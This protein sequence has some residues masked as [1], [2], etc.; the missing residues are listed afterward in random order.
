MNLDA[1]K[2]ITNGFMADD[3]LKWLASA[4]MKHRRIVEI[5][6]WTG[7]STRALTDNTPGVVYAVDTWEGCPNGDLKDILAEK[8][9]EW[10]F[11]EF[12]RNMQG[13]KNLRVFQMTSAAASVTLRPFDPFDMI[14]IDGS[15]DYKSV[16]TDLVC[17]LP[18]LA[19]NGLICGHDYTLTRP[20][21]AGVKQA[22]DEVIGPVKTMFPAD[23]EHS[24]WWKE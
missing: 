5:G 21:C 20:H 4:A 24:I 8:G 13:V 22:V 3:E 12:Q 6:S 2:A 15:H 23:G 11:E 16:R 14:F 7:R 10:A 17:W 9:E 1:A 19:V 18:L